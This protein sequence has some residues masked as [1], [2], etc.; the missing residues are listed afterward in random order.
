MA[1]LRILYSIQSHFH[2][3]FQ[4]ESFP[5]FG[6]TLSPSSAYHPQTDEQNEMLN[7]K[8]EEM[9]RLFMN[10]DKSNWDEFLLDFEVAHNSLFHETKAFSPFSLN[11]RIY[12][13]T[14]SMDIILSY[15]LAANDFHSEIKRSM[16]EA[17]AQLQTYNK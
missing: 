5:N 11:L 10:F 2:V 4:E 14:I 8:I 12:P 15:N 9:L 17:H 16:K 1:Y 13:K 3:Q 7:L 6:T